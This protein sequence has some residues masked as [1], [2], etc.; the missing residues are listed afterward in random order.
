MIGSITSQL[1]SQNVSRKDIPQTAITPAKPPH[2][3]MFDRLHSHNTLFPVVLCILSCIMP[4]MVHQ[5]IKLASTSTWHEHQALTCVH[6]Y[7][8]QPSMLPGAAA[9]DAELTAFV[10]GPPWCQAKLARPCLQ[11]LPA[12]D[13]LCLDTTGLDQNCSERSKF[14]QRPLQYQQLHCSQKP[15]ILT[16]FCC[17]MPACQV[18]FLINCGNR[19]FYTP[20]FDHHQQLC[21]ADIRRSLRC[22]L[23][24]IS[25]LSQL[26]MLQDIGC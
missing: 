24:M 3:S 4:A 25:Q 18:A 13:M 8:H 5:G 1:S 16:S 10:P 11:L 23:Q 22:L 14:A 12:V 7:L 9:L 20:F 26:G 15:K 6:V 17:S 19:V 2:K 21:L